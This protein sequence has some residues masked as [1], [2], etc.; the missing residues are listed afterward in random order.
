MYSIPL[1]AGEWEEWGCPKE[2][3]F[4]DYMLSYSPVDNVQQQVKL[5]KQHLYTPSHAMS[6]HIAVGGCHCH[7]ATVQCPSDR[8]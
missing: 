3:K 5:Q 7:H 2:Q 6:C 8:G 1:T 4:Y